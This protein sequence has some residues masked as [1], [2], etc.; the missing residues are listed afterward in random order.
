MKVAHTIDVP[1]VPQEV[2]ISP[3]GRMAYVSCDASQKIVVIRVRDWTVEKLIEAG[4]GTDGLSWAAR[5]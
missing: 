5:K 4:A 3:D 1:A 2:I